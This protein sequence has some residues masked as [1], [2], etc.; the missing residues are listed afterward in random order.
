MCIAV[1]SRAQGGLVF[2]FGILV[3][4]VHGAAQRGVVVCMLLESDAMSRVDR[5]LSSCGVGS[6]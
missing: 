1:S 6:S 2:C 5:F 3:E 4:A